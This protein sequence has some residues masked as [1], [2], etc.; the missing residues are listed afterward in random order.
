MIKI[1]HEADEKYS[2]ALPI[3]E[4]PL[5]LLLQLIEKAELDITQLSLAKVT[6]QYLAYLRTLQESKAS[7]VTEFLVIAAKLIQIKSESLLPRPQNIEPSED[8]LGESLARQLRIYKQ[9]K[10]I[11]YD[12]EKRERAG[13]RTYLRLEMPHDIEPKVEIG[14]YSIDDIV[15]A[16]KVLFTHHDDR[17]SVTSVVET[18]KITIKDKIKSI[19]YYLRRFRKGSFVSLF[20]RKVSHV[21]IV[22]T[23]LAML[24]LIKRRLIIVHQPTLFGDIQLEI[25]ENWSDDIELNIDLEFEE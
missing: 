22:V 12:L 10:K 1:I 20:D 24:E 3:Y 17:P 7:E 14:S 9:Y 18:P 6:D 5:D 2:V 21:D 15:E 13:L 23:F 4:G 25:T 11:A 19:T 16:A 8:D